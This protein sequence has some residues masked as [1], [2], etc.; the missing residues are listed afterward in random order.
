M[1]G[2][3]YA[4]VKW[5]I[6]KQGVTEFLVGHYGG[7]DRRAAYA[8]CKA[9]AQYPQVKLFL[10]LPYL[11]AKGMDRAPEGFDGTIYPEG[12][13]TVPPRAA[14]LRAN[15]WAVDWADYLIAYVNHP[16]SN[17]QK[18]ARYALSKKNRGRIRVAFVHE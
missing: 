15:R 6:E 17:A 4:A 10:L 16:A 7:F 1:D 3:L 5:H 13:E 8:V 11:P 18:V 12:M 2:C 9:K 14:I